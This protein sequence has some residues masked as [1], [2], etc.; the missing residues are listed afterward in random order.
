MMTPDTYERED[1]HAALAEYEQARLEVRAAW[2]PII[3]HYGV[4][5]AG[6]SSC[7]VEFARLR[8]ALRREAGA[9]A[10]LDELAFM[11]AS[12][13]RVDALAQR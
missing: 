13:A 9:K 6:E 7:P 1:E 2:T 10:W 8:R 12:C 4:A 11:R 5:P 3:H